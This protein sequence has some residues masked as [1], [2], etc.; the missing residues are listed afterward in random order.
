MELGEVKP[1]AASCQ[2]EELRPG[3]LLAQSKAEQNGAKM[4]SWQVS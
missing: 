2:R 1:K 4:G 3:I